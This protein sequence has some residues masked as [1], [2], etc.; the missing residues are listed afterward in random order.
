M[1]RHQ[2]FVVFDAVVAEGGLA[3]AARRLN[4]SAPT[5]TRAIAAF[6]ARYQ[7][8]AFE[9][10]TRGVVLTEA[11]RALHERVRHLL[12]EL[13]VA[14]HTS[15]G[16][17]R[18]AEGHL[19]V[20][21]PSRLG[22]QL[23]LP[24]VLAHLQANPGMTIDARFLDRPVNLHEE[25]IDVALQAGMLAD[26]SNYAVPVGAIRR[27]VVA[28]PA[29]LVRRGTPTAPGQIVQHAVIQSIA[30]A[31]TPSWTFHV[32]GEPRHVNLSPR[33][34]VSNND[35]AIDCALNDFGLTRV[36]SYQVAAHLAA[37][38]LH[39]LLVAHAG[40]AIP[41]HLLYREGR[42]AARKVRAF[43]DAASTALRGA[44]GLDTTEQQ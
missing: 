7:V 3:G 27:V 40:D 15:A 18:R 29:Y 16:M 41:L 38:T 21:A 13:E 1:D 37:G 2:E 8:Q 17:H 39:A 9:R 14:E 30:D 12:D 24:I 36:M 25:G 22:R 19:V 5:V 35:A 28:S 20:A 31:P 42:R 44:N 23:L 6:E 34:V 4:L 43:V 10:S 26:S 32:D 33:I 11:G